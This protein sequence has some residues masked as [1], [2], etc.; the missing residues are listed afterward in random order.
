MIELAFWSSVCLVLYAYIGYPCALMA[1]A[2]VR[3]RPVTRAAITPRVSFIITAHNEEARIQ[4]KLD[5]TLAQDYP[6]DQFDIIVA[7]DCSTDA[8]DEIVDSCSGRV[9][10]VRA[11]VRRGKEAAQQLAVEG[12][13]G[14]ILIF[15]DVATALA[16]N[17]VSTIVMN[18][19]DA[20]VG[21]VSSIDRFVNAD[22]QTSG[23]GAYVRYEMLLRTL[24]TRVNSLVGL[25]GSFFAARREVC[26][27]WASDR[28]SDFSTLLAAVE[29]GWRGVLDP[30]CPG[31]YRNI[32]DD[33][34]ELERKV[35]TVVRGLFVLRANAL[36]LN[37]FR[38]GL[39][40]WQ[41]A[42]H[43]LCRWLVPFAMIAAFL[44]NALLAAE[45]PFYQALLVVHTLAYLVAVA[46]LWLPIRALKIPAFFLQANLAVFIAWLRHLRGDRITVWTPSDRVRKLPQAG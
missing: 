29:L 17:A 43:K 38:Y 31:Y 1:I 19:A 46:G 30:R 11:P 9:R 32:A 10:L 18:F 34:R 39:F 5:N 2:L 45:S 41:L 44:S 15:S 27:R 36:M 12:A 20:T 4:E 24:E 40:A 33:R 8:T 16:P 42:S 6:R 7:S 37:P 28:Q 22:G 14:A 25:S 13:T 3:S 26:Q 35:R 21:C 23:E